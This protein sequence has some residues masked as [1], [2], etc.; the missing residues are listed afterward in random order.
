M[1]TVNKSE[2]IGNT[3]IGVLVTA[4][5]DKANFVVEPFMQ[6]G[7][8]GTIEVNGMAYDWFDRG[9]SFEFLVAE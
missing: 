2:N 5:G 1:I 3:F 8:C 4:F 6:Y 9:K 7:N